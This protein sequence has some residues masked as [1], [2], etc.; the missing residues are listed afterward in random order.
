MI[1]F[2]GRYRLFWGPFFDIKYM[3]KKT[4]LLSAHTFAGLACPL[5]V[6]AC[7]CTPVQPGSKKSRVRHFGDQD[8]FFVCPVSVFGKG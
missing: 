2:T 5:Y 8:I 3:F 4:A 1:N 7:L 6:Y